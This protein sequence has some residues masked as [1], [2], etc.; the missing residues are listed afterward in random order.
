MAEGAR[1]GI[2]ER[3]RLEGTQEQSSNA[4]RTLCILHWTR[5]LFS[6]PLHHLISS[7]LAHGAQSENIFIDRCQALSHPWGSS[8]GQSPCLKGAYF[9]KVPSTWLLRMSG[10]TGECVKDRTHQNGEQRRNIRTEMVN[11]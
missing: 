6:F 2:L 5:V 9:L 4:S 8:S 11:E 1:E 10:Y 3:R 7:V